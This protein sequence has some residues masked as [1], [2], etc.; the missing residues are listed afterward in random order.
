MRE[1][2]RRLLIRASVRINRS[3]APMDNVVMH[4]PD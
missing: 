3:R 4:Q 1:R 2:R